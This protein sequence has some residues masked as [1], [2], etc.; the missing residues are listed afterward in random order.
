MTQTDKQKLIAEIEAIGRKTF[1]M[2]STA[3]QIGRGVGVKQCL[4]IIR[5]LPEV[6]VSE[7]NQ[8]DAEMI[9]KISNAAIRRNGILKDALE[10]IAA[11]PHAHS[12]DVNCARSALSK[13]NTDAAHT[14]QTPKEQPVQVDEKAVRAK[15]SSELSRCAERTECHDWNNYLHREYMLNSVILAIRPYL[16]TQQTADLE[17]VKERE[18]A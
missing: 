5:K 2:D 1:M 8:Q 13:V 18:D 14:L 4:E 16:A 10:A 9:L 15:I 17:K 7:Y 3:W 6:E 12:E 11:N